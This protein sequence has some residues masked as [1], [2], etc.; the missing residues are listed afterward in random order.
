MKFITLDN[1]KRFLENITSKPLVFTGKTEFNNESAF[2]GKVDFNKNTNIGGTLTANSNAVFND[3]ITVKQ[4]TDNGQTF[5]TLLNTDSGVI[6]YKGDEIAT[7]A[8]VTAGGSNITVDD[9]LDTT[10]TNPVQNKVIKTALDNM[11]TKS[12]TNGG[13]GV[14]WDESNDNLVVYNKNN[15]NEGVSI[16]SF[17]IVVS[18][19]SDGIGI[20]INKTMDSNFKGIMSTDL[21]NGKAY[22]LQLGEKLQYGVYNN[23]PDNIATENYVNSAITNALYSIADGDS[24]GY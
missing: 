20:G 10:S 21:T 1:I 9:A 19:D 18:D 15:T 7:K 4:S 17:S 12:Y 2:N 13:C 5:T 24:K 6:S 11:L 23:E 14:K 3:G 8:D 16:N 22:I